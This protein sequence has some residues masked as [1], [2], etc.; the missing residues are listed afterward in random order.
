VLK[1]QQAERVRR[2]LGQLRR[3]E[4]ALLTMYYIEEL[5]LDTIAERYSVS[6][7]TVSKQL[8]AAQEKL[9]RIMS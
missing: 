2:A 7:G 4:R 1:R 8:F 9:K 3:K 5:S 6:R